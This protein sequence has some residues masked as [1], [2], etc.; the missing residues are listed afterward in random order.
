MNSEL[1]MYWESD[2][3]VVVLAL[4]SNTLDLKGYNDYEVKVQTVSFNLG[5][6]LSI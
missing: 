4:Y 3:C 2:K 5:V 1:Q 6:F